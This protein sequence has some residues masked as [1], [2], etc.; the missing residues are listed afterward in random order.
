MSPIVISLIALAIIFGG[1]L[2]GTFLRPLLHEQHLS[3]DSKDVMKLGT[4]MIATM[5]A[6]VLSLL[7]GSAKGTFDTINNGLRQNN[8]K[9]LLLDHT[10]AQYGS[11][12]REARDSL[13]RGVI[14]TVQRIWP[15]EKTT[16]AVDKVDPA[17]SGIEDCQAK[18][19]QLS[20]RNDDQRRLQS[21]ALQISDEMDQTRLFLIQQV[22]ERSFPMPLLALLVSW[23]TIIFFNFGL[24]T[25]RNTTVMAVLFVCA[26]VAASSLFLIL[27][28]DQPFGGLIKISS[29]PLLKALAHLGR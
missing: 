7:I 5:A 16:M 18:L 13:R 10:M 15:A 28:L 27:E 26:L 2:F 9:L 11:E 24:F 29:A 8:A 17:E 19:R 22:G 1:T 14:S 25:S 4:G 6:L 20:P 3:G 21:Q 12:T 23:L